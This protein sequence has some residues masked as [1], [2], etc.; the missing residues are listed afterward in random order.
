MGRLVRATLW[1]SPAS[2]STLSSPSSTLHRGHQGLS[3]SNLNPGLCDVMGP[4]P[5]GLRA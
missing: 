5:P 2:F 3:H 4:A 1:L